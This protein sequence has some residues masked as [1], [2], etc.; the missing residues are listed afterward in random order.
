[1]AGRPKRQAM[2]AELERRRVAE[3]LESQLEY[4][5][6]WISSGGTILSLAESLSASLS[7]LVVHREALSKHLNGLETGAEARLDSAR[8]RGSFALVEKAASIADQ[9]HDKDDVPGVKLSVDTKLRVAAMFNRDQLGEKRGVNVSISLS[10]QTLDA[11]RRRSVATARVIPALEAGLQE[12]ES[13]DA[14]V[15]DAE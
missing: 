10:G 4:A 13:V 6:L 12:L 15:V 8:A 2:I 1:M 9:K 11:F 5:E 7:P 14:E 3:E